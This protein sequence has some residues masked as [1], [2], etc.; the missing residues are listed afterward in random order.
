MHTRQDAYA[1][2]GA[3]RSSDF[4]ALGEHVSTTER[5]RS[6]IVSD[7]SWAGEPGQLTADYPLLDNHVL[8]SLGIYQVVSFL[9]DEFGIDV[10]TADLVPDNFETIG[11]IERLVSSKTG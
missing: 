7:L 2:S 5:I 10:E 11:A 4:L 6:I 9:Q 1:P 8:D 3:R